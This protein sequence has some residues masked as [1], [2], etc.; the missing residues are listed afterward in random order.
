MPAT[1]QIYKC[2]Y[3]AKN[4]EHI[5]PNCDIFRY[6]LQ[7]YNHQCGAKKEK[8]KSKYIVEGRKIYVRFLWGQSHSLT[9]LYSKRILDALIYSLP[10][11]ILDSN[12]FCRSSFRSPFPGYIVCHNRSRKLWRILSLYNLAHITAW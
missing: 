12:N 6:L 10:L 4:N 9:I 11:L 2:M 1:F 5:C 7:I 3:G 8:D